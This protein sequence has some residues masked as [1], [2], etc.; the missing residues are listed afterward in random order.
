MTTHYRPGLRVCLRIPQ[1]PATA[2]LQH[3]QDRVVQLARATVLPGVAGP[4]W[5]LAAPL[6]VPGRAPLRAV[7]QAW[8]GA[9]YRVQ[10]WPPEDIQFLTDNYGK[11]R[12]GAIAQHLGRGLDALRVKVREL[13][14]Q[15]NLAWTAADDALLAER[16]ATTAATD[17]APIMRRTAAAIR[18]RAE[19]LGLKKS[20]TFAADCAREK[21][22]AA[23]LFTPEITEIIELLYPVAKTDAIS[24]LVG[25][26]VSRVHA[27]AHARGWKKS[28]ET[29]TRMHR[30][31]G[32]PEAF[33][34]TQFPKGH[35]PANKGVRG[36]QAG[37]RAPETQF[38]KGIRP[39]TWRPIGSER[40]SDGYLQIKVSDTGYAPRDWMSK[41]VLVWEKHHGRKV[42]A[43]HAVVFVDRNKRNFEPDNL[44]LVTR[45]ELMRRNSYHTNLPPELARLVQLRGAM[46]RMINRRQRQLREATHG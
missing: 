25:L 5:E 15:C 28:A 36:W 24:H 9:A 38:K 35:V 19:L 22:R 11:V 3:L 21:N 7:A 8:L 10:P 6:D 27:F 41:H 44:L 17:L 34:R 16:Y 20:P 4:C 31:R 13:G 30:E 12:A 42:P 26:P 43:G 1:S 33:R 32:V 37:G 40:L 2:H 29:L 18:R 45:S 39:H 14:L 46:N 23:S